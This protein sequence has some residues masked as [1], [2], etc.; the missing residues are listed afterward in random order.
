MN[1]KR[2]WLNDM[3]WMLEKE[4]WETSIKAGSDR[5]YIV[6]TALIRLKKQRDMAR[7]VV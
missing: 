4:F 6:K 2:D 5:Y 7:M 3:I 1:W